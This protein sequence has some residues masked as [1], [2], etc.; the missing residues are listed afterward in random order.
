M[1]KLW[2]SLLLIAAGTLAGSSVAEMY[3]H[4]LAVHKKLLRLYNETAILLEY[5]LL[6]FSEIVSHLW[7][8]GEYAEFSFLNADDACIDVRQAVLDRIGNWQ[9]GL[10]ESSR[11]NLLAFFS[12]LGTTDIS[13]QISYARL[14]AVQEQEIISSISSKYQQRSGISRTFGALGGAFAAIMMI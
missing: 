3:K 12:K 8:S 1:L 11:S 10:E 2:G 6:T 4:R 9:T 14:A 7:Q 5:S 13:G